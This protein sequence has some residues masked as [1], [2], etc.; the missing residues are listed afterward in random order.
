M[1][2]KNSRTMG[3][4]RC[5]H[6][7]E[8]GL[9][10]GT[11]RSRTKRDASSCGKLADAGNGLVKVLVLMRTHSHMGQQVMTAVHAYRGF[12]SRHL[13]HLGLRSSRGWDMKFLIAW[14]RNSWLISRRKNA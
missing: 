8:C 6:E 5:Y 10:S 9:V 11:S 3:L 4:C 1:L 13:Y 14:K 12:K 2:L 7:A